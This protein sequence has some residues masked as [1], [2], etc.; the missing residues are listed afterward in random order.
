MNMSF[1]KVIFGAGTASLMMM[2]VGAAGGLKRE[3]YN[4][5]L[6]FNPSPFAAEA[7]ATY[8]FPDRKLNDVRDTNPAN[9]IG[10]NGIG[11]GSRNGVKD[12]PSY[13]SPRIGLKAGIG[14]AVDC[15]ID[16]SEPWGVHTDP[17]REWMGANDNIQTKVTSHNYAATCSYKFQAGPGQMRFLGG[18]FYQELSGFKERLVAPVPT[19]TGS[20][21]LGSGIGRLDVGGDGTGWRLGTAYEIPE[22][23]FRASLVYN[24]EVRLGDLS[25]TL[26]LTQVPAFVDPGNPILGQMTPVFGSAAMPQSLKLSIQSGVA[27]DWLA[28]GSVEWAQWSK[29]QSIAFC[30]EATRAIAC[31]PGGPTEVTS[32]DLIYRDGWTIQSGVGHKFND[33]LSAGASI[34]WDRGT[35]TGLGYQSDTWT[36]GLGASYT[37]SSN[38]ELRLAGA[39]GLMTSGSSG[40]VEW[41]GR[42][43]GDEV[44]YTYGNDLVSA[45]SANLKVRW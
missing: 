30:P 18:F 7:A 43:Y 1:L 11:G 25:G 3:G 23:A 42:V 2:S 24:S 16:Y 10:S 28:F 29:L 14:D 4:I 21:L 12:T 8:V 31:R 37:P 44:S 33:Q 15:L 35:S 32:L 13:W 6:L 9:G 27:P 5:D 39:L 20:N 17:G 19:L 38:V 45:I 41:D 34:T 26:N 36:L 22:F 40:A